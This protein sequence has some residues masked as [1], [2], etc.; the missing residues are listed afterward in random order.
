MNIIVVDTETTNGLEN[1]IAYDI[2]WKVMTTTG[3]T[4]ERHSYVVY[5][6]FFNKELMSTAYYADKIPMYFEDMSNG[7][8]KV[9]YL[10]NIRK[11]FHENCEEYD[12]RAISAHNGIFDYKSLKNTVNYVLDE[13]YFYPYGIELWD[14]LKMAKDILG[15][16]PRY[17]KFCKQN[18]YLTKYGKPRFTAEICFR[19]ISKNNEFEEKHTGAEDCDI[20]G[21][22]IAYCM[23]RR[24]TRA[25]NAIKCKLFKD[26]DKISTKEV[27]I[28]TIL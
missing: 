8:R 28:G 25:G 26:N 12:V 20:E 16:N 15:K 9:D 1:P 24:Y 22:I 5:E 27:L 6:T 10:E 21:A 23:K 11:K 7:V 2:G 3:K 14:S 4:L 13:K 17:V 19:Y 18:E